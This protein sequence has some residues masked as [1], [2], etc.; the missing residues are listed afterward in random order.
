MCSFTSKHIFKRTS[1]MWLYY[2]LMLSS[3]WPICFTLHVRNRLESEVSAIPLSPAELPEGASEEMQ[4]IVSELPFELLNPPDMVGHDHL[5]E[6]DIAIS[7]DE[8]QTILRARSESG[9]AAE[10]TPSE[11][12]AI[13]LQRFLWTP[14]PDTGM[15]TVHFAFSSSVSQKE[16]ILKAMT[17]WEGQTCV[18]FHQIDDDNYSRPYIRIIEGRGCWSHVGR[19]GRSGQELSIGSSCYREG[20][21]LHE[22]GHSLGLFH[23]QSRS[24]RSD[25]IQVNYTNVRA[26]KEVNFFKEETNNY[27]V[28]YDYSSIMHYD[29]TA[30][31]KNGRPTVV[32]LTPAMQIY[33][34]QRK[35]LTFRD[36]SVVNHM[37]KCIDIWRNSCNSSITCQNDGYLGSNCSCICPPGVSGEFCQTYEQSYYPP[38]VCG[39]N[40]TEAGTIITTPNFPSYYPANSACV[41]WIQSDDEC[42]RPA[43]TVEYFELFPRMGNG[44]CVLDRLE[45]RTESIYYGDEYCA[46]D[47]TN[48]TTVSARGKDLIL[49]FSSKIS[50]PKGFKFTVNFVKGCLTCRST[51]SDLYVGWKSPL[52]PD[53]YPNNQQCD[54]N[55]AP[56]V[57]KNTYLIFRDLNLPANCH[58]YIS[59]SSSYGTTE[60]FC[61]RRTGSKQLTGSYHTATFK[62]DSN[63]GT[64]GWAIYF[65]QLSSRCHRR[66]HLSTRS[67][68]GVLT[69]PSYPRNHPKYAQC[70]WWL[71]APP[72][73]RILLNFQV[74]NLA[75]NAY[76]PT[77]RWFQKRFY[78]RHCHRGYVLVSTVG[79]R[80]Y[81]QNGSS[82]R[83]CG[84]RVKG[85]KLRS[86]GNQ[87]SLLFYGSFARTRGMK[88]FYSMV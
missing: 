83:L 72:G 57:P 79:D 29:T 52:Y 46:K 33:I 5:L 64:Q 82:H 36:I 32:T 51:Q 62:S 31:S 81:D 54:L 39:G 43:I 2:Y 21:I 44:Q 12:K 25:Y 71:T 22:L 38:P 67:S 45:I 27:D 58:D 14:N 3:M 26:G 6:G 35:H 11:R 65:K 13:H 47:L 34:G 88:V 63:T 74:L 18:K 60:K 68:R 41:W 49:V 48:G 56:D 42:N 76:F 7:L 85:Y 30:F 80:T 53:L 59:I 84:Y 28:P 86:S 24:D 69:S 50:W 20:I 4:T 55:V 15:P 66:I 23:E 78:Q 70:E 16:R 77:R 1:P 9:N 37:Y 40:I 73:R 19:T 8:W 75:T 10:G 87:M 17:I 61:G